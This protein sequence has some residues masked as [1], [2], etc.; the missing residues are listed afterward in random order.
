M[1]VGMGGALVVG[2]GRVMVIGVDEDF[3]AGVSRALKGSEIT[4]GTLVTIN[5]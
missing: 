5:G 4:V 1:V 2:M 3:V